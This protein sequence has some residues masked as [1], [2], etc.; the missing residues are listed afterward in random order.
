MKYIFLLFAGLLTC[1][2]INSQTTTSFNYD[3]SGN[4]T[5]RKSIMLK[6]TASQAR[7]TTPDEAFTDQID[8]QTILIYPN[9]VKNELTVEIQGLEEN[10]EVTI[11]LFDQGG[12]LVLTGEK[13]TGSTVLNLSDLSPGNYYMTIRIDDKTTR[14]KIVKQE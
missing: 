2:M 3:D 14:W 13:T 10:A 6:S 4:R 9:P 7:E 8:N 11:T 1:V 5:S 12:R